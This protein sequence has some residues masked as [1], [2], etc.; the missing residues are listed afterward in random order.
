MHFTILAIFLQFLLCTNDFILILALS[1]WC[2]YTLIFPFNSLG[3]LMVKIKGSKQKS[4]DLNPGIPALVSFLSTTH[5]LPIHLATCKMDVCLW[6]ETGMEKLRP[7][8]SLRMKSS[9]ANSISNALVD[10]QGLPPPPETGMS[11]TLGGW[12]LCSLDLSDCAPV[13]WNTTDPVQPSRQ[14]LSFAVQHAEV[15]FCY[16]HTHTH[17][18]T[19]S[20]LLL[21]AGISE[22]TSIYGALLEPHEF[23][24]NSFT[25]NV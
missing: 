15:L 4:W 24:F 13:C 1:L 12:I 8:L 7:E 23:C 22:E 21:I 11:P 25:E 20:S 10:P 18:L 6:A 9:T 16:P 17:I 2:G 5:W 3:K 19:D 14:T